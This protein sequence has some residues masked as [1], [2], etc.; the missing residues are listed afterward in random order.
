[1]PTMNKKPKRLWNKAIALCW[2]RHPF[3]DKL[4]LRK[5]II[6]T[7]RWEPESQDIQIWSD[8]FHCWLDFNW[9]NVKIIY[10]LITK[11]DPNEKEPS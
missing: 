3:E 6:R 10:E 2:F 4:H 1:M 5:R 8:T 9:D 11:F 7:P